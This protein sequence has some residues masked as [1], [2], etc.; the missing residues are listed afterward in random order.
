MFYLRKLLTKKN[1]IGIAGIGGFIGDL[2]TSDLSSTVAGT[3][4]GNFGFN[5][6]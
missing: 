6:G 1:V 3:L 4:L 5:V 2:L